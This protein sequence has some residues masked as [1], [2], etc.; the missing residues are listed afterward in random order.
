MRL[1][2]IIFSL[3]LGF[4]LFLLLKSP[5]H[6]TDL[7]LGVATSVPI[8]DLKVN[9]GSIVSS[10]AKGF[11]LTKTPYDMSIIGVVALNAAVSI[12]ANSQNDKIK[13]YP[14][15]SSG[16]SKIL[17]SSINGP[18][19]KGDA[20]TS[21]P[22]PGV[23]MK[24]TKSGF[25]VG[26][27]QESFTSGD[28][29]QLKPIQANIVMRHSAPR[30]TMQRNLFDVANLSAVPWTEEPLTVFRYLMAALVIIISFILGFFVFGRIAARGVEALGRNP[31]AARV[32]QLGIVLNVFITVA[33]IAA[34]ILVAILILTI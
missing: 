4:F 13:R 8:N 15:V 14:V 33:I 32:I 2:A 7:T 20:I 26:I 25:I 23:G 21:S 1:K 11:I 19:A 12:E 3:L 24:A 10:S 18:I 28:T 30:A 29:K 27:A 34:G 9:N 31:L 22:I 6:G 16:I 5:I 17:V